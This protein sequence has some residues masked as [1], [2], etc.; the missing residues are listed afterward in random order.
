[1]YPWLDLQY[2]YLTGSAVCPLI[3]SAACPSDWICNQNLPLSGSVICSPLTYRVYWSKFNNYIWS[4]FSKST[5]GFF[6][7]IYLSADC[8]CSICMFF[9][10][11]GSS[12]YL[13]FS[14]HHVPQAACS[15]ST[16][17]LW[18]SQQHVSQA[19]FSSV[20]ISAACSSDSHSSMFL[21]QHVPLILSAACS[22]TAYSSYSRS[23]KLFEQHVPLMFGSMFSGQAMQ[24]VFESG[25]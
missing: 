8:H 19:A 23:S 16:M 7:C 1:M 17:F 4:I 10:L 2:I 15:R 20:I 25:Q 22:Q 6:P 3:G 13:Q 9:F 18:L 12:M 11:V 24:Y 5:Y 21:E 14:L